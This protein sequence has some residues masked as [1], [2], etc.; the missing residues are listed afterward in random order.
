MRYF[1]IY[2][3]IILAIKKTNWIYKEMELEIKKNLKK[4]VLVLLF[5]REEIS[6][7]QAGSFCEALSD[8]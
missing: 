1:Y 5:L 8:P 3:I 2:L 7:V 6:K 4:G